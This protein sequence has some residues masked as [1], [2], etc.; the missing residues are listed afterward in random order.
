MNLTWGNIHNIPSSPL[1]I[2]C[3]QLTMETDLKGKAG[4]S[5]IVGYFEDMVCISAALQSLLDYVIF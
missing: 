3:W 4:V 5:T 1:F 2:W